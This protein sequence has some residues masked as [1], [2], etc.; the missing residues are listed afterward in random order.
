MKGG[1]HI[2]E[3]GSADGAQRR[4]TPWRHVSYEGRQTRAFLLLLGPK[5]L[6]V[7]GE[8]REGNQERERP[9]A[10]FQGKPPGIGIGLLGKETS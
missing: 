5:L 9:G 2:P 8:E 3:L 1:W 7:G 4:K 6:V 10:S